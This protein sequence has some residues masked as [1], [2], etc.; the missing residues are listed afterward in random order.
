MSIPGNLV[1]GLKRLSSFSTNKFRLQTLNQ[2]S[3]SAGDVIEVRL[4]TNSLVDLKSFSLHAKAQCADNAAG[5]HF[6][7]PRLGLA[8]LMERVECL[9][10]GQVLSQ[11]FPEYNAYNVMKSN[12]EDTQGHYNDKGVLQGAYIGDI[13]ITA[14]S[15]GLTPYVCPI[16]HGFI[17]SAEPTFMSLSM[18]PEITLRI[19]LTG[20]EVLVC[21]Q[22]LATSNGSYALS[23]I[24]FTIDTISLPEAYNEMVEARMVEQGFLE[25]PYCQTFSFNQANSG[26]AS[27]T[28]FSVSSQSIDKLYAIQR[29]TD[30]S[31]GAVLPNP[32][33]VSQEAIAGAPQ[34]SFIAEHSAST[35]FF[36]NGIDGARFSVNN[37]YFPNYVASSTDWYNA[38]LTAK[39]ETY[40]VESGDLV[41]SLDCW[42]ELMWCAEVRLCHPGDDAAREVAGYDSRG[43]N[44]IMTF[45]TTATA[46]GRAMLTT[47]FVDV[48]SVLRCGVGRQLQVIQ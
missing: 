8:G 12:L 16:W 36:D 20:N 11:G 33:N 14:A 44:S 42:K 4:P 47:I 2:T 10:G 35:C 29:P 21:D 43:S 30:T 7:L 19:Y 5:E 40:N 41:R 1:Y 23:D 6:K 27:T 9:A 18:M 13:D 48:K 45:E 38:H 31:G 25:I 15:Q 24:Y 37:I 17:G 39:A 32:Y 46:A 26:A 28:R 34:N 3:A 22:A